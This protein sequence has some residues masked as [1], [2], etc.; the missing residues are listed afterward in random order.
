MRS[1][2]AAGVLSGLVALATISSSTVSHAADTPARFADVDAERFYGDAVEWAREAGIVTGLTPSCF[3]PQRAATRAEIVVVLHRLLGGDSD[4]HPFVD[5]TAPWQLAA[6]GWAAASGVTTGI[7]ATHFAP[8]RSATRAEVATMIWRAAGR[9]S[10]DAT[11]PFDDVTAAWQLDPVRWMA[12]EGHTTGRSPT[13]FD[14]EAPVTRG[15][16]L[17]FVWRWQDRPAPPADLVAAEPRNCLV[18][19][20]TCADPFPTGTE[21]ALAGRWPGRRFTTHVRDLRTGC[22]YEL[23]PGLALTTA[24]VIKAQVL[25]G[26][27]LRAQEQGRGLTESEAAQVDLMIRYSHNRPP[28]TALYAAVGSASGMEALDRRFGMAGTSHTAR[29]GATV[30]TAAD[31]TR[32]VEQLLVG[33]GPLDDAHVADAWE[34]MSTVSTA[35]TWGVSAGLP[36]GHEF[37]LK[38]GFYPLSGRGWR[39]GTTGVARDV[40]GGAWA[41]TVMTDGNPTEASGIDLVEEI[42]RMVNGAL[43]VGE[44]APRAVDGV[45]CTT[46]GS[47]R[48]W[49]SVAADLAV[50]DVALLRKLNGGESAPLSGQ[51]VCAP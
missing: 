41:L 15:E 42:V 20:G 26:V 48:S 9:P 27:E 10:V 28:T 7:D 16:L 49:S 44:P 33:G 50:D 31:R 23:H 12:F 1:R 25:A 43:T 19:T 18:E 47:G 2:A 38:N 21:A 14:P 40:D 13:V 35:Q 51:R 34:F 22:V 8:D 39:T 24:S 17:T 5:V 37:A 32:L 36:A 4:E 46:T 6:V 3:V 45:T 29:Y 11:L 30:S